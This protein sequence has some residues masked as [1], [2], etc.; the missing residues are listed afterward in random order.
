MVISLRNPHVRTDFQSL[1][2]TQDL[3]SMHCLLTILLIKLMLSRLKIL[4]VLFH[5]PKTC[6]I[7]FA[8]QIIS[9][10]EFINYKGVNPIKQ[11]GSIKKS[12]ELL[13]CEFIKMDMRLCNEYLTL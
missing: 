4:F 1:D 7:C 10:K 2:Q 8:L 11:H 13:V 3:F 5:L 12:F 9:N 6:T